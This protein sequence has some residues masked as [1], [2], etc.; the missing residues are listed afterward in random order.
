V[1]NLRTSKPCERFEGEAKATICYNCGKWGHKAQYCISTARCLLCAGEAYSPSRN[2][3]ERE[4][5]CPTRLN[6]IKN[7]LYCINCDGRHAAFSL[8]CRVAKAVRQR[9]YEKY[10]ERPRIFAA[11]P[12]R[13][14]GDTRRNAILI[15]D[16]DDDD[17]FLTPN[18]T[19]K[20]L[21]LISLIKRCRQDESASATPIAFSY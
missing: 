3:K 10:L 5:L 14:R 7:R 1:V 16:E 15:P 18:Y 4:A 11:P 8:N 17:I 19:R 2:V 21:T 12:N 20:T 13:N 6:L 9:A